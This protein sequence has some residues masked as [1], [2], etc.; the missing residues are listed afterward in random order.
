MLGMGA[1]SVTA[2]ADADWGGLVD[3]QLFS[4]NLVHFLGPVGWQFSKQ[5]VTSLS[6]TEV[7]H[8]SFSELGQDLLWLSLLLE[9]ISPDLR[10]QLIDMPTLRN[11]NKGEISLLKNPLYHPATCHINI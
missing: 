8:R 9:E 10:F 1:L 11:D 6:M 4:G 7:K 5:P 3:G 2:W